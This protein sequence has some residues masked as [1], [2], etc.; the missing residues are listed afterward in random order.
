LN[1]NTGFEPVSTFPAN[2]SNATG[3][4]SPAEPALRGDPNK[5]FVTDLAARHGRQL[6]RYLAARLRNTADVADLAQ[7]VFLRLIRVDRHDKIRSPEAY[8][9]TIASHVLHQHGLNHAATPA[10][11]D[12]T[13][14]LVDQRLAA[15][16]DPGVQLDLQRRMKEIEGILQQLAPNTQASLLLHCRDGWTLDEIGTR[17][18]VSR[19]MV[20]KHIAKAVLHCRQK[21]NEAE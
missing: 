20:K 12:I 17:L 11:V 5:S 14:P 21:M 10:S 6:R 15:E 2:R 7:E 13:D 1:R 8:L 18:G 4:F 9:F 19:S 16:S 3:H